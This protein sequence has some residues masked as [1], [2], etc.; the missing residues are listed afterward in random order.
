LKRDYLR[1]IYFDTICFEPCYARSV[2]ES[3]VVDPSHLVL[4][5]DTPFPLG[6]PDP[7]GFVE[8]SFRAGAPTSPRISCIITRRHS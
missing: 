3:D 6:E 8:R 2:V 7:V 1:S 4:G 5:S